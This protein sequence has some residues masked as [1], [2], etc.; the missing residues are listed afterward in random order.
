MSEGREEDREFQ[1]LR[2]ALA[3]EKERADAAV[4]R[5][6]ELSWQGEKCAEA[7]EEADK[8]RDAALARVAELEQQIK[9]A[10]EAAKGE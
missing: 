8:Q 4:K 1:R 3:S 9:D 7:L 10:A 2:L 5:I 6:A